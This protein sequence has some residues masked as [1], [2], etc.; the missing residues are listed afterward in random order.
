V[1][2]IYLIT[3]RHTCGDLPSAVADALSVLP[4][5]TAAVQLRE[6][7]LPDAEVLELAGKL[8][9]LCKSAKAP[10]LINGRVDLARAARVDGVHL[11]AA[12]TS[13][14]AARKRLGPGAIIGRSCHTTDEVVAA[15]AGGADFAL[16]GPV[17]DT[18]GKTAQGM[19]ALVEAVRATSLPVFAVGGVT[20]QRAKRAI[21][22]GAHGVACIRA[23]LGA[24]NPSVAALEMWKAVA[25]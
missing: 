6:K 24:E 11:P 23:V 10:L 5:G 22:A 18:P 20:P 16:F 7:D 19:T 8:L 14:A 15:S 21:N 12:G 2:R 3:D 25:G 1:V 4:I 13:I 9:P 17:W